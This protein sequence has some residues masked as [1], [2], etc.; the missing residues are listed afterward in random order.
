VV[1][2]ICISG[3]GL[4]RGYLNQPAL[5]LEKFIKLSINNNSEDGRVYKTGD[6]GR[7]LPD[8]NIEYVG[9]R[10]EQ[11]KIRGYRI[12][13]GEI[14][15]VL[16]QSDLL[17][18]GT[19]LA[20]EDK[21]G[22]KRLV[23][24]VVPNGSFNQNGIVAFLRRKLPEYMI[25]EQWIELGS[26]PLTKNGKIDRKALPNPTLV[27]G[28]GSQYEAP[29]SQLEKKLTDIWQ[30]LLEV[31]NV[32]VHDNFFQLG[33]HS[34]LAIQMISILRKDLQIELALKDLFQFSTV[35]Q[36]SKYVE[37]QVN[38]QTQEK[39]LTEFELLNI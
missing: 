5:T 12:E 34:L 4:A 17:H 3:A 31:E 23:G 2:E 36:L 27:E 8:G 28:A 30:E 22:S 21:K 32:G 26:L 19:V 37:F 39:D 10:D 33:G 20:W 9:R 1:G 38:S 6:L 11:V 15:S 35:Q 18:Q 7:W 16:Q 13:L 29:R 14:E 25:P 24:Y